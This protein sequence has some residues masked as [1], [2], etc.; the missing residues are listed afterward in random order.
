MKEDSKAEE[1]QEPHYSMKEHYE[2]TSVYEDLLVNASRL[3]RKGGRLVFL[4]HT[5]ASLPNEKNKFPEH[6]DF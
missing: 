2:V 3:L 5:D 6:P 1:E 4:F